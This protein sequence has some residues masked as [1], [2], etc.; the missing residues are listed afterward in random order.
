MS[1][2]S[3]PDIADPAV[4]KAGV[5]HETFTW[6][7]AN[8]PV[9][10]WDHPAGQKGFWVI[11]RWQDV[12]DLS[13]DTERFSSRWGVVN[14]D[15]LASDQ[16][17]ARRTMLEEDP[18][19]HTALRALVDPDFSPRAIKAW[20]EIFRVMTQ[21]VLG[22]TLPRQEFD[23]V[24]QVS[25]ELPIRI[26]C[27]IL[28]VPAEHTDDLVAWGNQML[29]ASDP[30]YHDPEL[31]AYSPEALRLVPFGHPAALRAFDLAAKMAE[32]RQAG[33][34]DD[35]TSKLLLGEVEGRPL[36]ELEF[37]ATWLMLVIAGN[38]TTRHAL[39]HGLLAFI[40]HPTQWERLRDNPSLL[41]M[42]VEEI[43][44]W[45]S[46][47]N[48]HR[49]QVTAAYQLQGVTLQP[50]DKLILAFTSA[51]RDETVFEQPFSFD[52]SRKPNPHLSFGRGGPHH[53]LGAF[54]ARMEIRIV[55]EEFLRRVSALHLA[56]PVQRLQSNHLNGLKSL[57]IAVTLAAR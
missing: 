21:Q 26:L 47:I 31:A 35:I 29:G 9:A 6:L 55:F 15:D 49:R 11:S 41:G 57:P 30:D 42:A 20:T 10:W 39:S 8:Q 5:P 48:W 18:P 13:R 56:G 25:K 12:V 17:E 24:E 52:I 44:R 50:G 36:S 45:A 32:A 40:E 54:L 51:N 33:Q 4:W 34:L 28:G 7:R 27:R 19:R 46:P 22:E 38:E 2:L 3:L 43:L 16:L 14:L 1:H 53:C 37:K 23:F